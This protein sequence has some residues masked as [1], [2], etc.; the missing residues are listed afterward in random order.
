M[1]K[2]TQETYDSLQ[3][4][5]KQ[6]KYAN[7]IC[8]SRRGLGKTE[9]FEVPKTDLK[10]EMKCV[11]KQGMWEGDSNFVPVGYTPTNI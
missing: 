11:Q 9:T 4:T 3:K 6:G 1:A 5:M 2:I 8:F 10:I 7:H